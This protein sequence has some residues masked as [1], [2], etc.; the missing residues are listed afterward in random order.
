MRFLQKDKHEKCIL[1]ISDIHLG[2]GRIVNYVRNYLEDF[3][4]DKELVDFLSY[5]SSGEFEQR[6]VELIINGDLF[7]LLAVPYIP[8]FDDEFWRE[9]AALEKLK[10]I[11]GAHQE[12]ITAFVDFISSKGKSITYIIG[13]HDGELVF[14]SL[15]EHI[16]NLFPPE[17]Q[18]KF[19]F[20]LENQGQYSPIDGVLIKHGHDYE[21]AHRFDLDNS[22]IVDQQ[23][24]RYFIPPWGSYY[25]TR[26]LN[27]FKEEKGHI[28]AVRPIR[29]FVINGLIY[30]T[31]FTLRFLIAHM[32][33]F[34]MVR[35]VG[36]FKR[37]V[38]WREG[39][40]QAWGE[41]EL[42]VDFESLAFDTLAD[43]DDI[44]VLIVGHTHLPSIHSY[45]DGCMFINTG[46]WTRMFNL[47]FSGSG[48][49]YQL[50]YARIDVDKKG[51]RDGAVAPS[52][53][54]NLHLWK[55]R[56]RLPFVEFQ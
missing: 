25:V 46:T 28:N 17:H 53:E 10:V 20:H 33:Y 39:I 19:N 42:F 56:N 18:A 36:Y 12:V 1:V 5:Y 41:L 23:G 13:N 37:G 27:K 21:F 6:E 15:R 22:I 29:K 50:T 44:K 48:K 24:R 8:Y 54:V 45:A 4:F 11:I 32:V 30:D 43:R 9:D 40:R 55:G 3:C 49:E 38:G 51:N 26:I 31:F 14:E 47:D 34:V 16:K 7:D 52:Y 35:F 2:A